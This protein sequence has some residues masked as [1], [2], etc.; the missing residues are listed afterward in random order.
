[1]PTGNPPCSMTC[2]CMSFTPLSQSFFS[3]VRRNRRN[4][5]L[6]S[7]VEVASENGRTHKPAGLVLAC[8]VEVFHVR[9]PFVLCW[10]SGNLSQRLSPREAN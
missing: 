7:G 8:S 6:H 5:H 10:L 1:M 3:V 9:F 4:T 2:F